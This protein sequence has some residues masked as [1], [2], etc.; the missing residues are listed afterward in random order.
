[1]ESKDA[2]LTWR[3]R[4]GVIGNKC[5]NMALL[6]VSKQTNDFHSPGSNSSDDDLHQLDETAST[7]GSLALRGNRSIMSK[8]SW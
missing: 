5:P 2:G 4:L 8:G 1:M 7:W 3:A 6:D